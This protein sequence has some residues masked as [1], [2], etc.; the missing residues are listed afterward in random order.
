MPLLSAVL[1]SNSERTHAWTLNLTCPTLYV[2]LN[3]QTL[4]ITIL[5]TII[6]ILYLYSAISI[7]FQWRLTLRK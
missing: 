6:I 7:D 1:A 2:T 4:F 3:L 5:L